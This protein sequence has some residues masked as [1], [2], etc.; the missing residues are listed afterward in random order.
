MAHL[1]IVEKKVLGALL[2][3]SDENQIARVSGVQIARIMGYKK[4]GGAIT[5]ALRSL[6]MDNYIEKNEHGEIK[7]LL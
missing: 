6:E 5:F 3:L 2:I 4:S 7:V 1:G